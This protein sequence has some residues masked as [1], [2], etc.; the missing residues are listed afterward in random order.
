VIL[1]L[2]I[3]PQ[4]APPV[5]LA[6]GV[7]V[8]DAVNKTGV[9]S[10]I[11]WPNDL[12]IGGKK[13][14]G[15]L[16]ETSTRGDRLE[17]LVVGIGVN[18][19]TPAFPP[20]LADLATSIRIERGG[21]AVDREA[22]LATLLAELDRW[23]DA[24]TAGGPRAIA[25]AWRERSEILGKRLRVTVDGQKIEG[26]ARELD[27]DGALCLTGD[28]GRTWRVL[29]GEIAAIVTPPGEDVP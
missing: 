5:T 7:A 26:V 28:D 2:S 16:A 18:L 4:A 1:R 14:A 19:N 6:A 13:V 29:S 3:A 8:C 10:S 17:A 15:I 22:F 21:D 9:R 25:A 24:F 23:I 11:K 27:D 20:E 12:L